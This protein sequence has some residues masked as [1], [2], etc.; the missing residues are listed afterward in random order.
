MS[1]LLLL[2]SKLEVLG[3]LDTK[4][5]LGLTLLTFKTEHNF[6]RGFC[7]F[8]E[9]WLGLSTETH[10]FGIITT[11]SLSKVGGFAG[12]VLGNLVE[13][14]FLASLTGTVGFTFFWNI[15]HLDL[16]EQLN[17]VGKMREEV[18]DT[19]ALYF[20]QKWPK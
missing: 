10:L 2:G 17:T 3:T 16:C 11:L 12:F 4:L 6:T 14:M 15:H 19:V 18:S 13:A 8:V 1:R 5:L 20:D 9:N 7:F